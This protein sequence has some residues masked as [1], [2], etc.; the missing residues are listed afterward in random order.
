[1]TYHSQRKRALEHFYPL[2]PPLPRRVRFLSADMIKCYG[3][4]TRAVAPRAPRSGRGVPNDRE[5]KGSA[6][7]GGTRVDARGRAFV[8]SMFP[9]QESFSSAPP[10]PVRSVAASSRSA[11]EFRRRGA[12]R[13]AREPAHGAASRGSHGSSSVE[14]SSVRAISGKS[15]T[16]KRPAATS[17]V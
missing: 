6:E 5:P 2:H 16:D 11:S 8:P 12:S 4:G 10:P 1:M 14:R 15:S 9:R 3:C 13:Q 17:A 7:T